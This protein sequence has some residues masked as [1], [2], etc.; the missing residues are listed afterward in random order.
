MPPTSSCHFI[1]LYEEATSGHDQH[2][3][4]PAERSSPN[5]ACTFVFAVVCV[6]WKHLRPFLWF[7]SLRLI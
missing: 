2:Y 6:A 4:Y 1:L 3:L 5:F 7:V